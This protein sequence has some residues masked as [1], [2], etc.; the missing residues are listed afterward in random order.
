VGKGGDRRSTRLPSTE[1]EE[2]KALPIST[3]LEKSYLTLG[4]YHTTKKPQ[5]PSPAVRGGPEE[6]RV[7]RHPCGGERP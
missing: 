1:R 7:N 6:T 4:S 5:K 3:D 2:T